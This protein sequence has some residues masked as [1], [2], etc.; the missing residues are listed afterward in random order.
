[1]ISLG[2]HI[3]TYTHAGTHI[4]T[5]EKSELDN[6]LSFKSMSS[7]SKCRCQLIRGIGSYVYNEQ[8][9]SKIEVLE[10]KNIIA[11]THNL[12]NLSWASTYI[13]TQT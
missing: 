4:H 6:L 10:I 5:M 13:Q 2:K 1:M 11:I 8:S 12:S 3:D 9:E 7:K